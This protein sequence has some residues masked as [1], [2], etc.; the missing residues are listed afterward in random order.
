MAKG[1]LE[2][3]VLRIDKNVSKIKDMLSDL[4]AKIIYSLEHKDYRSLP[5][6]DTYDNC[7]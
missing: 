6:S 3:T 1:D 5:Y 4:G 2:T 7:T